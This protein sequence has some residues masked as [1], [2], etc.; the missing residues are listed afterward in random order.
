MGKSGNDNTQL[1]E[2]ARTRLQWYTLEAS[3]E[4]FDAEEVDALVNLLNTL[5]PVNVEETQSAEVILERFHEYVAM[6]D[7]EEGVASD[8]SS[9]IK[10]KYS[11]PTA[12]VKNH[13]LI[14]T[15]AA[16][17][18]LIIVT[19]GSLGAV[20]A[21]KGNG[22]FYWLNKDE[23]GMTMITSPQNMGEGLMVEK[24]IEYASIDDVPEEYREYLVDIEEI[25]VLRDY[26]LI[27]ITVHHNEGYFGV[28]RCFENSKTKERI[29]VGNFIFPDRVIL[30]RET[31]L[32]KALEN[33]T[34][35]NQEEGV[36]IR[37]NPD[38][39][40]EYTIYFYKDNI[41]YYVEGN[42]NKNVLLEIAGEYRK[43]VFG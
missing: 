27:Y 37:E 9:E 24:E 10:K 14:A 8:K 11:V 32:S 29:Y 23:K 26:D 7:A 34:I 6:R 2:A 13:K 1:I 39:N 5:E 36:L 15:A 31:H 18:I 3:E 4:E 33:D 20:N 41:Q 17:F 38:G 22:F 25:E 28:K 43:I 21:S 35:E 40:E 12:F 42:A 30:T 19:G 16:I